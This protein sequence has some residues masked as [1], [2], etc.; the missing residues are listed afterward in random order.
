MCLKATQ[1]SLSVSRL[2]RVYAIGWRLGRPAVALLP[3]V[4]F[5]FACLSLL[6]AFGD[7]FSPGLFF[8]IVTCSE[9][10]WPF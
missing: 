9:K 3:A 6:G 8:T 10:A 2:I 7:S 4:L 5:W 1:A